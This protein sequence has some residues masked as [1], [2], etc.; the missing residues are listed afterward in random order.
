MAWWLDGP[1]PT[2]TDYHLFAHLV[3]AGGKRWGQHDM[4]GLDSAAWQTGDLVLTRF[5]IETGADPPPGQYWIHLGMYTFPEVTNVLLLDEAGNPV[6]DLKTVGP[7]SLDL[8]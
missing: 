2:D 4:A 5:S 7:I 1:P 8:D 6:G 3:D